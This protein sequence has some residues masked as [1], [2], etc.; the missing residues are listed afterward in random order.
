MII[1][2]FCNLKGGVGK[3]TACQNMAAALAKMGKR[4]A[5]V[6]MDP[7]SNLSAGFG[8]NLSPEDPQVFDLLT[9]HASWD[10]IV[11]TREDVD[12]IPSSL[13]LVMAELNQEGPLNSDF[14][15]RDAL[16]KLDPDRYDYIF[17]DSPP[18]LGMFTRNV[19]AACKNIIVPMDGG[20]Y[21]LVGLRL[22][23]SALPVLRER[24]NHE[25]NIS[26]ILMTN[27]NPRLS[28]SR[29]VHNDVKKN[30]SDVLFESWIRPNVSLVEASSI[31]VSILKHS[32][33]SKG[34]ECYKEVAAEFLKR[35]NDKPCITSQAVQT[36]RPEHVPEDT[37]E[38]PDD[39]VNIA[40]DS[41]MLQK[42]HEPVHE[43]PVPEPVP[44]PVHEESESE[45][46]SVYVP[47]P[48]EL[49]QTVHEEPVP[50]HEPEPEPEPKPVP[51]PPKSDGKT[52]TDTRPYE[53]KIK[54]DVIDMLPEKEKASWVSM[55]DPVVD[56]TR[57]QI[58]VHE[59][60]DNFEESDKDRFTFYVLNDEYN[61]LWPVMYPDQ[62]ID[63][64]RCVIKWDENGAAE[65][66]M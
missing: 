2:G 27:Y 64:L 35:M 37:I 31:G 39:D 33:K 22:L 4:I 60:R 23:S 42:V 13:S 66:F 1:T 8:L 36:A 57:E 3:T 56:I 16:G 21:S 14:A 40:S 7:Q 49:P 9:G 10:D 11:Q 46:E 19:L 29:D 58:D 48:V 26:G 63:P 44:V 24:L 54:Q 41:E 15:L 59:L 28:I 51:V 47:E 43:E 5:V 32:P 65:V 12:V 30:F 50:V 38:L 45:P 17:L 53:R 25:L 61:T 55:L 18:Q 20:F 6:D 52:I 62:I 34:A